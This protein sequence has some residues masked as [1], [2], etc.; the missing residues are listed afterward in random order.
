M[1]SVW[2]P[3]ACTTMAPTFTGASS[4]P[5]QTSARVHN[6]LRGESLPKSGFVHSRPPRIQ[7]AAAIF[8]CD[9]KLNLS[10]KTA[11]NSRHNGTRL[12]SSSEVQTC[13]EL[14]RRINLDVGDDHHDHGNNRRVSH[15]RLLS[16]FSLIWRMIA[17]SLQCPRRARKKKLN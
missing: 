14:F 12:L 11:F 4:R 10:L 13:R 8:P 3:M 6:A 16:P 1:F 17:F 9:R 5:E 15:C 2:R 7:T